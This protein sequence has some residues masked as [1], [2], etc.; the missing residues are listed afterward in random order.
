MVAWW[1]GRVPYRDA[2]DL[3][4][5]LVGERADGRIADQLL[6][7]EHPPVLTLGRS[8]DE[9]HVLAD[10]TTLVGRGIE[11]IRVERGP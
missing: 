7:L 4:R 6:L 11:V 5:R 8:S 3:Q 10:P 2:H 9:R 1:L